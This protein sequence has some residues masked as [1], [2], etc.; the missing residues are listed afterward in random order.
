MTFS[1]PAPW[2]FVPSNEFGRKLDSNTHAQ[3][4]RGSLEYDVPA[5]GFV[6]ALLIPNFNRIA[7]L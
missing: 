2:R 4:I 7:S 6:A 3:E 5:R 1:F